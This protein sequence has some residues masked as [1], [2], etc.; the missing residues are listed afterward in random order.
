MTYI[1][2]EQIICTNLWKK[3]FQQR[4]MSTFDDFFQYHGDKMVNKNKKRDVK[5]L[6]LRRGGYQRSLFVKRFHCPHLKDIMGGVFCFGKMMPLKP[7][8]F[9]SM[10]MGNAP[11][12]GER[13]PSSESSPM[14]T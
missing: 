3:Y 8:F 7:F 5:Q 4:G 9:A 10:A 12:I 14:I 6:V 11:F 13:P 1:N 2:M